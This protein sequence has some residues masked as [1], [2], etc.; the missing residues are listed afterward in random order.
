VSSNKTRSAYYF[1]KQYQQG[2]RLNKFFTS[3]CNT[4]QLYIQHS[5]FTGIQILC[6]SN[7]Y[8]ENE[9]DIYRFSYPSNCF[10]PTLYNCNERLA[11]SFYSEFRLNKKSK[12]INLRYFCKSSYSCNKYY[13]ILDTLYTLFYLM[14]T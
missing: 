12:I 1:N 2:H 11:F 3:P 5:C 13:I 14:K 6:H 10:T 9:K 4:Q 8:G 7:F